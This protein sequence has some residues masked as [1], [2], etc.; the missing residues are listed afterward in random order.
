LTSDDVDVS[1]FFLGIIE[2]KRKTKYT[3][4]EIE[5]YINDYCYLERKLFANEEHPNSMKS[6]MSDHYELV[7]SQ[8]PHIFNP[9]VYAVY[10][11]LLKWASGGICRTTNSV[12]E[13]K[14]GVNQRTIIRALKILV[15][16]GLITREKR[17]VKNSEFSHYLIQDAKQGREIRK[18]NAHKIAKPIFLKVTHKPS[19][20]DS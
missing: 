10:F 15:D 19:K 4:E 17:G 1:P 8:Y 18:Q 5:Q 11:Y 14:T 9:Y 3:T 16:Y 6:D 12:I 2:M 13:R 20:G 7:L